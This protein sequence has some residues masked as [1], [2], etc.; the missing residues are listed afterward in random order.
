[1]IRVGIPHMIRVGTPHMI[2]V[3]TPHIVKRQVKLRCSGGTPHTA[4]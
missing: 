4:H 3:G 2:R 1:M